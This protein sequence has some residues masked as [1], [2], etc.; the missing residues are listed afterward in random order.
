MF[1]FSKRSIERMQGVHPDLIT[2]FMEAIKVS[3]IDFGIPEYGG[4]R[5]AGEQNQLYTAK[6]SECDGVTT[7][8]NHQAKSD[9]YGWALDVYAYLGGASWDKVHLAMVAGVILSVADRLYKEGKVKNKLKW[10]GTFGSDSFHGWD[11]PH[12][13][14]VSVE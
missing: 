2:I 13:E 10:G 1:Q 4:L 8:S 6:K 12:F 7:K 3:P 11:M 14:L 5:T 9:G